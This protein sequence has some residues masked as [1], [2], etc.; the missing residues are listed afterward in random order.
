MN[1]SELN[2]PPAAEIIRQQ[3][4][5]IERLSRE[6]DELRDMLRKAIDRFAP[7][8]SERDRLRA[9]LDKSCYLGH[10]WRN[11]HCSVCGMEQGE[12]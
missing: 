6:R 12:L 1:H 4:A 8:L 7:V 9:L 10:E 2:P 11:G 3:K 5:E